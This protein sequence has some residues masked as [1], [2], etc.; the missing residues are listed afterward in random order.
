MKYYTYRHSVEKNYSKIYFKYA[1]NVVIDGL[2]SQAK[3]QNLLQLH[4]VYDM[5]FKTVQQKQ[6]TLDHEMQLWKSFCLTF[7][8]KNVLE[9]MFPTIYHAVLCTSPSIQHIATV[10]IQ[11]MHTCT[12]ISQYC[13]LGA[14]AH[15]TYMSQYICV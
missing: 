13:F 11:T 6:Q 1:K 5:S 3:H 8:S 10:Y 15:N 14:A 7:P 4:T 9:C 2:F 12:R